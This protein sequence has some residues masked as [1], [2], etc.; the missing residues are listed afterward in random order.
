M[1]YFIATGG[2][3]QS[4]RDDCKEECR[5]QTTSPPDRE[6]TLRLMTSR[7]M[8]HAGRDVDSAETLPEFFQC[9]D[10]RVT[11]DLALWQRDVNVTSGAQRGPISSILLG[12]HENR[13]LRG[14]WREIR[15][16]LYR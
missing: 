2:G 3:E 6:I 13:V 14:G 1:R 7:S 12:Y 15:P 11:C 9:R 8:H 5:S 16:K 4:S 10:V